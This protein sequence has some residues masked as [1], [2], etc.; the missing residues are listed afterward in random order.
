MPETIR[1]S[2]TGVTVQAPERRD[3]PAS[4]AS[5]ALMSQEK[6]RR[7]QLYINGLT[8]QV[9]E[10]LAHTE[11]PT[12]AG[13]SGR[14]DPIQKLVRRMPGHGLVHD[15]QLLTYHLMRRYSPTL[16]NVIRICRALE[17]DLV[18]KSDDEGLE[19]EL[20]DWARQVDVGYLAGNASFT[21]LDTYLNVMAAAADE[22]GLGV[23]EMALM[24]NGRGVD[25]LVTP[26]VRTLTTADR[27]GDG[28]EELYQSQATA[29]VART[30]QRT[31][32]R[33]DDKETVQ[34][35]AFRPT[36]EGA[37]PQ[38]LA[39][40][41]IQSTEAVMR[42][43]ESVLNG[44]WRFGDPSLLTTMEFSD[45]ASPQMVTL[46]GAGPD[47]TDLEVPAALLMLK[48]SL[49]KVMQAR[50]S[51]EVGD[52]FGFS[53]GGQVESSTLGQVDSTLMEYFQE[54]ASVFDAH[55]VSA[56][57]L[58]SFLFP[59]IQQSGDGLGSSR[60]QS[61]ASIAASETVSRNNRKRP[62]A[63]KVLNT[64]L[65]LRGDSQFVGQFRV[66]FEG[67]DILDD[68]LRAEAA[69]KEAEAEATQIQNVVQKYT[70]DGERRFG[71]EA[72]R[73]LEE[74]GVYPSDNPN[75]D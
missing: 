62:I 70:E 6:R 26:N 16:N 61:M 42:M 17:G 53:D 58:P 23:G 34:T 10:D 57:P 9:G 2:H 38:P 64:E 18:I 13:Y 44:W 75:A 22:Y 47:G 48:D 49:K 15:V 54:H 37:W 33:L 7:A 30:Q 65:A 43:Y 25:R 36:A 41:A 3:R 74:K 32:R 11:D 60:S 20:T 45:D 12:T 21:G 31:Q 72:E 67:V 4:A 56:A 19:R 68:K 50:R 35:L 28:L 24:D 63:R 1:D 27:D 14:Q 51:G 71:G 8:S 40:S 73:A 69:A 52:A 29:S 46:P 66:E 39:W 55:V 59:H 5:D